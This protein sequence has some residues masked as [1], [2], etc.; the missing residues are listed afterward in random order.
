MKL[1]EINHRSDQE[2]EIS[3]IPLC[4]GLLEARVSLASPQVSGWSWSR[5]IVDV[6][7]DIIHH[8]SI[9]LLSSPAYCFVFSLSVS[10]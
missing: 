9:R 7:M 8:L 2:L 4:V 5:N 1:V 3:F 10:H 6:Q